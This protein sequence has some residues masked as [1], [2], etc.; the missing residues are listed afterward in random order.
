MKK[1]VSNLLGI[2]ELM[3]LEESLQEELEDNLLSILT[4]LNRTNQLEELLLLMGLEKLLRS[5]NGYQVFKNG[6]I[7][8]VG[9]SDVKSD[10]LLTVASKLG[11]DKSR[12]ELHLDYEDAVKF[13][14]KKI[15]WQTNYSVILVGPMPHSG[16]SKGDYASVIAAIEN[17]DGYP[18]VK[19]LGSNTLKITKSDFRNKIIELINNGTVFV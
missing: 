1:V 4:R 14:F 17:E 19:R 16:I 12:V 18:P 11:I 9:Q 15:Q 7:L 3:E 10:V 13:D 5:N 8:V 2:E 6:K